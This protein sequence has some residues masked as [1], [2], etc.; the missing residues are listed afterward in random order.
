MA[1]RWRSMCAAL[2]M[3]LLAASCGSPSTTSPETS[4]G[5]AKGDGVPVVVDTDLALDDL[6]ALAF[7]PVLRA[8]S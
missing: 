2:L 3:A 6:V 5:P 8:L 4:P 7:L 1:S